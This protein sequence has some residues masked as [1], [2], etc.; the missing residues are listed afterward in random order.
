[1]VKSA[2]AAGL[3]APRLKGN[4]VPKD[5]KVPQDHQELLESQEPLAPPVLSAQSG[6]PAR[7]DQ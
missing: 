1:V 3:P 6:L 4:P 5:P 2:G 7:Q